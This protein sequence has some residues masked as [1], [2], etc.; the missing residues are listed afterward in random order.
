ML[1]AALALEAVPAFVA[2]VVAAVVF[3]LLVLL[4]V[5]GPAG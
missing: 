2:V 3:G 4:T 1:V 5:V